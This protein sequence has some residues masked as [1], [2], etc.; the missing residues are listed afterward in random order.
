[1]S[2][3]LF[4]KAFRNHG[5]LIL[6]TFALSDRDLSLGNIHVFD[7][8]PEQLHQAEPGS[9]QKPDRELIFRL[10]ASEKTGHFVPGQNGGQATGSFGGFEFFESL[11]RAPEDLLE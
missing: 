3:E 6:V 2:L 10:D 11:G 4:D 5:D 1:M 7:S 9:I 8:E